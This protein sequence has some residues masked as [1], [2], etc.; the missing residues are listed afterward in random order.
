MPRRVRDKAGSEIH[1]A[2]QTGLARFEH[3]QI[4]G[5]DF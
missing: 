1:A 5:G 2:T 3:F 4:G